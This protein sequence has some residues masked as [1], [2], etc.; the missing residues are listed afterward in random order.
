MW[1]QDDVKPLKSAAKMKADQAVEPKTSV[2][3][4]GN[5][6]IKSFDGHC[7]SVAE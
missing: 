5:V 3:T 2:K 1:T 7:G 6:K 4:L